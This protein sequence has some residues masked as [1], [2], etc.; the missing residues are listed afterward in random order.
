MNVWGPVLTAMVTP[1]DAAG[2][3]DLGGAARLARH[4]LDTGSDGLVVGATTG[5]GAA[6]S[7]DERLAL[8]E[9]VLAAVGDVAPVWAATGTYRTDESVALSREA[10]RLGACGLLVVTPYYVRPNPDGLR[11]HYGAVA[12]ASDLPIMLY[13]V[14]S[15]TGTNMSPETVLRLADEIPTVAGLKEA[16]PDLGQAVDLLRGRPA[17]FR[18]LSGD[19]AFT[20]PLLALGG[21]GVVSV[22]SAVAGLAIREM[23]SSYRRGEPA[24]AAA[25]HRG[26]TPLFR[27]LFVTTNPVPVKYALAARGIPVGEVRSPLAPLTDAQRRVV[28]AALAELAPLFA[29]GA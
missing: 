17:G 6:L 12:D 5:E 19:D 9:A 26:L 20:L 16:H 3:L 7:H 29:P 23:I 22:C 8:W 15:R 25:L 27:A 2:A 1:F 10:T 11:R 18:V 21:D 28:D 4:L 24:R 14:P 13:N